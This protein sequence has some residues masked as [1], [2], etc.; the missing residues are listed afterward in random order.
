MRAVRALVAEPPYKDRMAFE[1]IRMDSE[2]G[3]ASQDKYEW[4]RERHGLVV[5]D[6]EGKALVV[7]KGHS[8][9]GMTQEVATKAFKEAVDPLLK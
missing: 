5:L 8:W 3:K 7:L 2:K 9:G 4:G 1:V 6:P